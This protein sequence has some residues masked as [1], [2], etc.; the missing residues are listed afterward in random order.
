MGS[1]YNP[2]REAVEAIKEIE[3][4]RIAKEQEAREKAIK[5]SREMYDEIQSLREHRYD[6]RRIRDKY[7]DHVK[8]ELLEMAFNSVYITAIS[9]AT[10]LT[11]A[12]EA[13]CKSLMSNFIQEQGGATNIMRNM[14]DKTYFLEIVRS[15]VEE[16]EEDAEEKAD[17]DDV[18]MNKVPDE[19]KEE[20]MDKLEK[21][22]D[23]DTAVSMIADRIASA[24]EEFIK[25]NAEDKEKI[26]DIVNGINDRIAAVKAD[27]EMDDET[28]EDIQE[29]QTILCKRK[30]SDVYNNRPHTVFEH[31]LHTLTESVMKD[32]EIKGIYLEEATGKPDMDKL[33]ETTICM[34]GL[35][36]FANTTGL[37][38]V[39][40][41][42]IKKIILGSEE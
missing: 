13:L 17:Q 37:V 25:K 36:E 18:D 30:I 35:L 19:S 29:E 16:A 12:N 14:K 4:A 28:K 7:K 24:E 5:E 9:R 31:M 41:S 10:V 42:Y 11:E 27:P 2:I 33:V 26:E 15:I 23:V 20:M 39:D 32:D 40:E 3:D 6:L 38:K 21:E 8:T 1:R 22:D 34:Y